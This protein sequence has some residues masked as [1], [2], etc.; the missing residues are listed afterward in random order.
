MEIAE[1]EAGQIVAA[2]GLKETTTGDTICGGPDDAVVLETI[3][4]PEPVVSVAIEPKSRGDQDKLSDSLV[5]MSDEDPTFKVNYD[6]ETGQTVISGM[7]ELHLDIIVDRIRREFSVEANVG[8][9][10]VSYRETVGA[11]ARAEGRFVRQ[12]GGHGQYGHVWME[13]EPL[14]RGGG[15]Q[16]ENKIRGGAIPQEFISSVED[17]A[18]EALKTGPLSGFPVVDAKMTLVDGSYHEVDSSK[19]SFQIAGSMAAKSLV[20]ARQA[21]HAGAGD[22]V[23]RGHAGRVPGG[24]SWRPGAKAGSDHEYR[25]RGGYTVGE[26]CHPAGGEFWVR[27]RAEVADPGAGELH[28]GVR[29]LRGSGEGTGGGG[30]VNYQL[31]IGNYELGRTGLAGGGPVDSRFRG[32]DGGERGNDGVGWIESGRLGNGDCETV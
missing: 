9:P 4:F 2:V 28:H 27:E 24:R 20:F 7:G 8:R 16:F 10:R 11:P 13:I 25:G 31:T 22:E 26:G 32:N 6:G 14:D 12:T 17:G 30:L 21:N 19:M 29:Q 23:G 18:R 15:I 1:V 5:S 3:T